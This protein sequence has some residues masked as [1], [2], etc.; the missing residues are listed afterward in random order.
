MEQNVYTLIYT[1]GQ[2]RD[3]TPCASYRIALLAAMET[4]RLWWSEVTDKGTRE[5]IRGHW[6]KAEWEDVLRVWNEWHPSES[7]YI[8]HGALV[9]SEFDV[10]ALPDEPCPRCEQPLDECACV[11]PDCGEDIDRCACF[12][13]PEE[14]FEDGP[15]KGKYVR[16]PRMSGV[17]CYVRADDGVSK[18]KLVMVGDDVPY[19][20]DRDE[21]TLIEREAFC[22]V[23]GQ[24]GCAHD[25]LDRGEGEDDDDV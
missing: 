19:V 11:C 24:M 14:P 18:V 9:D 23:C 10:G 21:C 22:G 13:E 3:L 20:E 15:L 25:G 6:A 16:H 12:D 1:H 7:L 17:A 2:G 8:E 4:I 5:V